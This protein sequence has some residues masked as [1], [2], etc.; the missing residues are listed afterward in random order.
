MSEMKNENIDMLASGEMQ[1]LKDLKGL[2]GQPK[3]SDVV[4]LVGA[5]KTQIPGHKAILAT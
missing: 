3:Y 5:Q 1:L 2:L 4:F